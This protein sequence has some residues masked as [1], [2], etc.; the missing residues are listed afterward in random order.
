MTLQGDWLAGYLNI[1]YPEDSFGVD[2]G[3]RGTFPGV[4]QRFEVNTTTNKNSFWGIGGGRGG[5]M[6]FSKTKYEVNGRVEWQWVQD[7]ASSSPFLWLFFQDPG[8][9]TP[10]TITP[11]DTPKFLDL[12][13]EYGSL[14]R[15][16]TGVVVDTLTLNIRENEIITGEMSFFAKEFSTSASGNTLDT[17]PPDPPLVPHSGNVSISTGDDIIDA[18]IIPDL[19]MVFKNNIRMIYDVKS[20]DKFPVGAVAEKFE[21]QMDISF[22]VEDDRFYNIIED[23]EFSEIVVSLT[24][25]M[26][27][28]FKNAQI[29]SPFP[30]KISS[31]MG[32][33]KETYTFVPKSVEVVFNA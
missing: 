30:I 32:I 29:T 8:T 20:S 6:G 27:I 23:T 7:F 17:T 12:E 2:S 24:T 19:K 13:M 9:S 11:G 28:K 10:Y 16:L 26:D 31:D 1:G 5:P 33:R 15:Y 4:V 21:A 3:N 18:Y 25:S 14:N 22:L